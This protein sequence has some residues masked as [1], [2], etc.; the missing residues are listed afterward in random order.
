MMVG[1]LL[2]S[3]AGAGIGAGLGQETPFA[4]ALIGTV[5]GMLIVGLVGWSLTWLGQTLKWR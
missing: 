4:A 1:A 5:A 2:G 3:L